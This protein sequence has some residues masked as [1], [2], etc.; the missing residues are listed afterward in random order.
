MWGR[1]ICLKIHSRF[2]IF[3]QNSV[4]LHFP[5]NRCCFKYFIWFVWGFCLWSF[6][7]R[8]I[9]KEILPL[10]PCSKLSQ[11][12]TLSH[13]YTTFHFSQG[14][15]S[16]PPHLLRV[17]NTYKLRSSCSES[18]SWE[19][20]VSAGLLVGCI[21]FHIFLKHSLKKVGLNVPQTGTCTWIILDT[22]KALE[23]FSSLNLSSLQWEPC[24]H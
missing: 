16:S 14:I 6:S 1:D 8:I 19:S 20:D 22:L 5:V 13:D 21:F 17:L 24:S 2:L 10:L 18:K 3:F 4:I 7:I 9:Q 23:Q 12:A 15:V 11:T